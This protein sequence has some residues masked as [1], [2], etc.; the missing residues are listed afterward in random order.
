MGPEPEPVAASFLT[1]AP[2]T[3]VLDRFGNVVGRV[4]RV[5]VTADSYFDGIIVATDVGRRFVDAPEVRSIRASEVVLT[6]VKHD[7]EHPGEP[8]VLGA[9]TARWGRQQ[10]IPA[11]RE[12]VISALKHAFVHDRLNVDQLAHAV[13]QAHTLDS[14]DALEALVPPRR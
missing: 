13:E 10:V 6:T 7:V 9:H 8:R 2:K 4:E 12:A 11:D 5:L 3:T 1:L 14:L